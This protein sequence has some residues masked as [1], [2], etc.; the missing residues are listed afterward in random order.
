VTPKRSVLPGPTVQRNLD[1]ADVEAAFDRARE[2]ISMLD[3]ASRFADD[4][5]DYDN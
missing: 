1:S 5:A 4:E 2:E 3:Q